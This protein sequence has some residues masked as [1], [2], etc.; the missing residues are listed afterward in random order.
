MQNISC[1]L[2]SI[3]L[4]NAVFTATMKGI[5]EYYYFLY[6]SKLLGFLHLYFF[7]FINHLLIE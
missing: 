7:F 3:D 1:V 2:L 5:L 4:A 6:N